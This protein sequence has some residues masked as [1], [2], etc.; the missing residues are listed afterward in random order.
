M[1]TINCFLLG[2]FLFTGSS[3]LAQVKIGGTP[4]SPTASAILQLVDTTRGFLPTSLTTLQRNN[5]VSPAN[6]LMIYNNNDSRLNVYQLNA[7]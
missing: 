3:V 5:I 7:W 1:K 6:G 2:V 4:G